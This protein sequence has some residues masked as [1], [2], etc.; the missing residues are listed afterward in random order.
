M[1]TEPFMA[2][3]LYFLEGIVEFPTSYASIRPYMHDIY[4]ESH[5]IMNNA[6]LASVEGLGMLN[7][8]RLLAQ[9][10]VLR[11]SA[12]INTNEGSDDDSRVQTTNGIQPAERLGSIAQPDG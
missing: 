4:A 11:P 6:R 12:D 3:R 2:R 7:K 1:L 8:L 5:L 9:E 10:I